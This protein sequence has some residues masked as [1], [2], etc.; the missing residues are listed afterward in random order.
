MSFGGTRG[1][2]ARHHYFHTHVMQSVRSSH[3]LFSSEISRASSARVSARSLMGSPRCD[4]T[5]IREVALPARTRCVRRQT[6]SCRMSASGAVAIVGFPPCPTH[7]LMTHNTASLSHCSR[8]C[9]L[10]A[11][12]CNANTTSP[13]LRPVRT[14]IFLFSADSCSIDCLEKASQTQKA[15]NGYSI[16]SL[17][18]TVIADSCLFDCLFPLKFTSP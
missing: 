18:F 16:S 15:R 13:P 5:L 7:F 1:G 6:I 8:T 12:N 3:L 4:Y 2:C 10:R 14:R 17:R 9:E 11:S